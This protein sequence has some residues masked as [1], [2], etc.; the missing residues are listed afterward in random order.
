MRDYIMLQLLFYCVGMWIACTA[1]F[2]CERKRY[3]EKFGNLWLPTV[4]TATVLS[5][6]LLIIGVLWWIVKRLLGL[7]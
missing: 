1:I 6:I 4:I 5:P 2:T 7:N 3:K